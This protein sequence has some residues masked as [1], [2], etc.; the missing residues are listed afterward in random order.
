MSQQIHQPYQQRC[1]SNASALN[2][3]SGGGFVNKEGRYIRDVG[4]RG[5][6]LDA[7]HTKHIRQGDW[8]SP[9][10][11]QDH[12]DS[13]HGIGS[14]AQTSAA[15]HSSLLEQKRMRALALLEKVS[16]DT[17]ASQPMSDAADDGDDDMDSALLGL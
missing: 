15:S 8:F 7:P 3:N 16:G 13:R 9:Q 1:E 11:R 6:L 2:P 14:S 4:A 5:S 10:P 17:S 12:P